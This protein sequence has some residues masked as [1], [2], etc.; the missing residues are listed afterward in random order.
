[1]SIIW[2]YCFCDAWW[3]LALFWH[4]AI[5][6]SGSN[7]AL[8]IIWSVA[9]GTFLCDGADGLSKIE[10]QLEFYSDAPANQALKPSF[11]VMGFVLT[12]RLAPAPLAV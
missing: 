3:A 6:S 11:D 9:C 10:F 1:L 12:A 4:W 2:L 5:N 7:L 8:A